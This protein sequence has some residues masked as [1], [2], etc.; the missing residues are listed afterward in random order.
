MQV[1]LVDY[2][3]AIATAAKADGWDAVEII[4]YTDV[5]DIPL[6]PGTAFVSPA[7][8]LGFMD[9]GIDYVYSR[10][11]FPGIEP[12]VKR[13]I[14]D[15]SG[16]VSKLGRPF[17]P[18][19]NALVVPVPH[20]EQIFMVVAPT[21][22][23]PQDVRGTH[24][25]YHATYAALKAARATPGVRR[26]VIPGMCTGCGMLS[27]AEAV[28]QMH[29]A[30]TDFTSGRPPAWTSAQIDNEQPPWYENTEFVDIPITSIRSR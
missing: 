13:A 1:T 27:P 11:M 26:L 22:L 14:S 15:R 24:N 30:H 16:H 18:I 28:G 25:A 23:M 9:G 6:D 12:A 29:R 10:I 3:G 17:L 8:S 2:H 20:A 5:R 4:A 21:M 19:G 7:N